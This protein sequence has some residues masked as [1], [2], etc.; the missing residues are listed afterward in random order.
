MPQHKN[1]DLTSSVVKRRNQW[2]VPNTFML[3]KNESEHLRS[4]ETEKQQNGRIEVSRIA[5]QY[6]KSLRTQAA[7]E[8]ITLSTPQA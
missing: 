5:T 1:G 7:H 3:P 2:R 4:R 6:Y 8:Y